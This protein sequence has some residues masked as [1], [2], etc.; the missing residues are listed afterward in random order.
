MQEF[1]VLR[2][3]EPMLRMKAQVDSSSRGQKDFICREEQ[4]KTA[5]WSMQGD[6]E[7]SGPLG[8]IGDWVFIALFV[9]CPRVELSL[10]CKQKFPRKERCLLDHLSLFGTSWSPSFTGFNT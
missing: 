1:Q 8:Q 5:W 7:T 10:W 4:R 2:V 9:Y 3:L 6:P